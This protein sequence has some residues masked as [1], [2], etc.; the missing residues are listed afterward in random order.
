[1]KRYSK[2][3]LK[4]L[5]GMT[6]TTE[7]CRGRWH[8]LL[9]QFGIDDKFLRNEH[10]PCPM[11][12]GTDRFR[13][14]DK[15]GKGTWFCNGCGN[16]DGFDL[17]TRFSGREF[18]DIAGEIAKDHMWNA[19]PPGDTFKPK[20]TVE[21]IRASLNKVWST[22]R[23]ERLMIEYLTHRGI[24]ED[25][26]KAMQDV[27]GH[28]S[29]LFVHG[30]ERHEVPAMVAMVRNAEGEPVGLHR[31]YLM[32]DGTRHKKLMSP[33]EK[34]MGGAVRLIKPKTN[35]LLVAE[36]I[37]SALAGYQLVDEAK[38]GGVWA[39]ISAN[40]MRGLEIPP[41]L[42]ALIICADVDKSWTGQAAAYELARKAAASN[43]SPKSI[44]IVQPA[45]MGKDAVDLIAA[46]QKR[47][48][49]TT[50]NYG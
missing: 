24:N 45:D 39:T 31:T 2:E 50:V 18:K 34:L 13:F 30:A 16:G 44:S 17:I 14:D 6:S 5:P 20:R 8:Y 25:T 28:R 32:P 46:E 22:A 3:F 10:G 7:W 40:G 43:A 23:D 15:D 41:N 27:R 33:T 26:L 29:L 21:D 36:G 1:M 38:T 11:C 9:P 35:T 37:E 4:R 19:P 48:I 49:V 42:D 12:E 47:V